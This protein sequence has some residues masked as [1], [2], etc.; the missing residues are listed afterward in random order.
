[1]RLVIKTLDF[2][3]DALLLTACLLLSLIG[4]YATLD[5]Y[6]VYQHANDT[7]VLKFKP[8]LSASGE[9]EQPRS[10]S[11]NMVCWLT[12]DDSGV[13]FPVMQGR[14]NNE[15]LNKDPYGDFSLSGSIFLDARNAAD[16]TD[17]YS[18]IYGHHME[19]GA[20]FGCLDEFLD[21]S[22]FA[23]H[24]DGTLV[25]ADGKVYPLRL[26]AAF[27]ADSADRP[28]FA[29]NEGYDTL[30][31]VYDHA[32]IFYEPEGNRLIALTT[33]QGSVNTGRIIVMGALQHEE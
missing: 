29:P 17:P 4:A 15:Y 1:M 30:G 8:Q 31:F 32:D 26:F 24:R 7:S 16:F 6:L 22:Y 21:P 13:D 25:T 27:I 14:D 12:V 33:C 2:T 28:I 19:H 23:A 10:I 18:L 11:E 5:A 20:M 9:V 3:L